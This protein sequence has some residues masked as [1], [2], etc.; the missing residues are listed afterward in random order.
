VIGLSLL[1]GCDGDSTSPG[2]LY[3]SSSGYSIMEDAGSLTLTVKRIAGSGGDVTVDYATA[4]I[5]ATAGADYQTSLGTL[6]LADGASIQ[7]FSI[8]IFDDTAKEGTETFRVTLSNPTGGVALG[9][10]SSVEVA[11]LDDETTARYD[12]ESL[13]EGNINGQDNW[14]EVETNATVVI[15]TTAVNGSKVVRPNP[16]VT[17]QAGDTE[18]TRVNDASFSFAPLSATEGQI[19]YDTTADD[20]SLFALGRDSV[21]DGMLRVED[22]EIGVP[23]GI[24]ERQFIV[25]TGNSLIVRAG[26]A[27]LG[28]DDL[29]TDWYRICLDIDFTANDGEGAGS[30]SSMNLSRGETSLSAIDGLQD[31]DLRLL[32]NGAP[33]PAA[34]NAMYLLLRIDATNIPRADNLMPNVF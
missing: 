27:D 13:I 30:L 24:W 12:F 10:P 2:V 4:D 32:S 8:P 23:F 21:E 29:Q 25:L 28:G 11:I 1:A 5:S 14:F 33:D 19:C 17:G 16:T 15:D 7:S 3:F 31:L 26:V 22:D 20:N 6:R 18:L 9:S 34:W